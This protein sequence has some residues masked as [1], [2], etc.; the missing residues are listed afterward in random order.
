MQYA[1][2]DIGV[3]RTSQHCVGVV[4]V[5]G[6]NVGVSVTGRGAVGT[7]FGKLLP[8]LSITVFTNG[9]SKLMDKKDTK[10]QKRMLLPNTERSSKPLSHG[11]QRGS[12]P[13]SLLWLWGA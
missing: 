6:G 2:K 8:N 11:W 1:S 9:R 3:L 12:C 4:D 7:V 10:H 5:S 13:L